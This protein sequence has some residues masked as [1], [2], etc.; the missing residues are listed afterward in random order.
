MF[1]GFTTAVMI[2]DETKEMLQQAMI[3]AIT[4]IRNS[5]QILVRSDNAPA[6]KSLSQSST[7]V[8]IDN[9]IHLQ[10]GHEANKNCNSIVDKMIQELELELKK[11]A[12]EGEKL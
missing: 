3:Q 2:P 4:P 6:F 12:P 5:P 7:P 8:L 10:L 9:G 1:S 11:I